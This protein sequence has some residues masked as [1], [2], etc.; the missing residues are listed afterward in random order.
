MREGVVRGRFY[1]VVVVL[2][3]LDKG[4]KVKPLIGDQPLACMQR[5]AA[6]RFSLMCAGRW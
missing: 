2:G 6:W 5:D 3:G 1:I 4:M